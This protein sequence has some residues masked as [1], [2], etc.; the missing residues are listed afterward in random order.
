LAPG[1]SGTTNVMRPGRPAVDAVLTMFYYNDLALAAEWYEHVLG[2]PR[3]IDA[4]GFVLLG[5]TEHA[6]LAL[7]EVGRGSQQP[8]AG[9][10]KGAIL[11]IQTSDLQRWHADLF[12]RDVPG[13]GIGLLVGGDGRTIEFKILD[14]EG[15]TIEF[16]EWI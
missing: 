7:V 9:T 6:Q 14:P 11:S 2:F 3:L 12:A 10:N 5:I 4:D 8:I 1:P 13:T 16:F 15:Y